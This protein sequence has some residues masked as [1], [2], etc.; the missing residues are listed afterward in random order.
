MTLATFLRSTSRIV[1]SLVCLSAS[2]YAGPKPPDPPPLEMPKPKPAQIASSEG[3]APL[4]LPAV[5]QKRQ[6]KKNPPKPPTLL[7]KISTSDAED[8]TRT[9]DDVKG[10]LEWMSAEMNVHFTSSIKTFTQAAADAE[11]NPILYR[12]GYKPFQLSEQELQALRQY[13]MNGGTIIFNALVGNPDFYQSAVKAA[14]EIVPE[15]P[16]YRL[17]MDHPAFHSF[18][19]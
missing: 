19:D 17:R 11:K 15:R 7:T 13:V 14:Q 16:L 1:C 3:T 5:F 9:P 2:L 6:E 10:L 18:Y 4:P 8:W 12:S